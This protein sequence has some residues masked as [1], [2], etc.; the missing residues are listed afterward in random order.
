MRQLHRVI[1]HQIIP[2]LVALRL[3]AVFGAAPVA[4]AAAPVLAAP[5]V[6]QT[7]LLPDKYS[8]EDFLLQI[9]AARLASGV[10][11]LTLS[12]QLTAAAHAKALDMVVNKYWAHFGPE[13]QTPWQ[14]ITAAG[15]NYHY[16]GENLAR[17]FVT[18][19]GI[20]RALLASPTHRANILDPSY[21]NVGIAC[22][23]VIDANGNTVL[24]TIQEFGG[25]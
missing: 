8:G 6:Q 20:M 5:T 10:A 15:Y 9:N 2:V 4:L 1:A 13:G 23:P 21:T 11:P 12:D 7:V 14:F 17:G 19:Q 3:V 16:A 25:R 18:S 22:V 24:Y